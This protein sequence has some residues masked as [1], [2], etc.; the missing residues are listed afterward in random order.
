MSKPR[1]RLV[2][3]PS[4]SPAWQLELSP[5]L[6][7]TLAHGVA[8]GTSLPVV[9]IRHQLPYV[10]LGPDDR[11]LPR[12]QQGLDFLTR[13]GLSVF[14]RLGGGSAVLLDQRCL[15]FAVA[16]PC[17]DLT[18]LHQNYRE[19][20][21]G[22]IRALELLGLPAQFGRAP[23]SY[24]EGPYDIVVD[25]VKIAGVAQAIRRG[26]ALVSGMILIDQDPEATT[27]LLNCFYREAGMAR[28]LRPEA[29]TNLHRLTGRPVSPREVEEAL[30]H[31]FAETFHLEEEPVRD[32]EWEQARALLPQR[33]L[34]APS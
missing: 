2:F 28:H 14:D 24:C 20:A 26:F 15:S 5:V 16:R 19:L 12:L 21:R 31:G 11:R 10:L 4:T 32:A 8:A 3:L 13:Q 1:Y 23:G 22:A 30:R 25:G 27:H 7:E 17:R 33:R 34:A 9:L 18:L 29:V 6:A